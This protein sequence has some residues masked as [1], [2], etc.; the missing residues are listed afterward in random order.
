MTLFNW[1]S[2]KP[3]RSKSPAALD[4][5]RS[6]Q[7]GRPA[8]SPASALAASVQSAEPSNRS[9]ERKAKRHARREQLYIA[10]RESMTRV[11]V[12]SASYKFK[13]L[14]LDQRGDHFLV[15]MDVHPN[16]GGQ[17]DTLAESEA[18]IMQT[19]KARFALTV[20]SVY[21]R[22]DAASQAL[23]VLTA[24]PDLSHA[25]VKGLASSLP[26]KTSPHYRYEPIQADEVTAF[27]QALSNGAVVGPAAVA[28]ASKTRRG[29]R[30]FTLIT[31]FEDTEMPDSAAAP[32]LSTTQYGE[33]H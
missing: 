25:E 26:V 14:S 32:A 4:A 21:W 27:K 23:S 24:G 5:D 19:A 12:L 9:E 3:E 20:T 1:F 29:L 6:P 10:V 13:V 11:G 2:G 17:V 15:M 28:D 7:H 16:L 18:L 31:G 8:A 30:S 22:V 33:L